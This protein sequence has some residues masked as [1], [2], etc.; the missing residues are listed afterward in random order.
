MPGLVDGHIHPVFGEWTPTQDTIGWIGNYVHGGTTT[1]VSACELHVPGL[2]Y[3]NLT[4]DLVTSLAVVTA[5]TTGRIR[6]SGAKVHAGTVILV[7]GMTEEHFDRLAAAKSILRQVHLLS[8]RRPTRTRRCATSNGAAPAASAPRCTP[9]ACRAPGSPDV[10]LR[11]AVVAQARHRRAHQRRADPDE[12]RRS[13]QGD[14]HHIVRHR[15]LL[16]RQLRLDQA[17]GRPACATRASWRGSRSAPTR[18][19]A[20]ASSRAACC[21][22]SATSP[23]S[24]ACR[25]PRRSPSPPATPRRPTASTSASWRPAGRRTWSICGPV[26]GSAGTSIADAIAP[27]RP[28]GHRLCHRRRRDRGQRPQPPDAAAETQAVL[29]LLRRARRIVHRA[30]GNL[31]APR[32]VVVPPSHAEI[33]EIARKMAPAGF[34]LVMSRADRAEL[35]P[36]LATGRIHRLLSERGERRCVLSRPR[37]SSSSSSC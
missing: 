18:R 8:A 28:A 32:I 21:A 1:M 30:V 31:M 20:P 16:V 33:A 7:P 15:N 13:R 34:E 17:R 4:P 37:R 23:R 6:W 9:A 22:T 12:R 10:R 11:H 35:E 29:L 3:E 26:E 27:R 5:A 19:A 24:A 14:R 25:R 36:A 2:D